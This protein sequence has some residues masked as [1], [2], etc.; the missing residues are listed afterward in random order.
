MNTEGLITNV[1]RYTGLN[2][3]HLK[4]DIKAIWYRYIKTVKHKKHE[5]YVIGIFKNNCWLLFENRKLIL[6][7]RKMREKFLKSI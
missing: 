5:N 7:S 6:L 3:W 1:D 2:Q 4:S